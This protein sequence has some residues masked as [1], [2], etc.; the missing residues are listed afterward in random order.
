M[1]EIANIS[2]M[3][4][5][6]EIEFENNRETMIK[7]DHV[8]MEFNMASEQLNSLKE[9]A[10]KLAKR[11]LYFKGFKALDNVSFEVKKGDV[12]GI[13]GTNGSGKSTLLKIIAGVLEPSEGKCTVKGRIA[14]LIELGAGFDLEL[15]ARE[16]IYL[17]G[18][19]LGYPKNFIN[20]HF[21]GIVEF[22]EIE[23][24]LDM[25]MKN[26]SSG[27]VARIAFAIATVIVPEV[28]IVDEVLSVGDFMFQKK[29]ED[30]IKEL[31]EIHGVTVLI[32][33]HSHDQIERLCNKVIWIDKGCTLVVGKTSEISKRYRILGGRAGSDESKQRVLR[34]FE[35]E[36]EITNETYKIIAGSDFFE[37]AVLAASNV[38]SKS[39]LGAVCITSGTSHINTVLANG[40]SGAYDAPILPTKTEGLPI[41]VKNFLESRKPKKIFFFDCGSQTRRALRELQEFNWKPE[42]VNFSNEGSVFDLSKDIFAYGKKEKVWGKQAVVVD[43][44]DNV[45]SLAAASYVYKEKCPV[46]SSSSTHPMVTSELLEIL[47]TAKISEVIIIGKNAN[48]DIEEACRK[49]NINCI[50]FASEQVYESCI[51]LCDWIFAQ[52]DI[53]KKEL[54]ISSQSLSQWPDI[55]SCGMYC[56]HKKSALL[57]GDPT[58]LDSI[59][60]CLNFIEE[61]R[62]SISKLTFFGGDTN[63][64][65]V[66]KETLFK[67]LLS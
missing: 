41:S 18:A 3:T 33:S 52:S 31:I 5:E 25:P 57:L 66:E 55:L 47:S 42:I 62:S 36:Y 9:Y 11:Q 20:E 16:N 4:P 58:N 61:K 49:R 24:F 60:A 30:R 51:K 46:F 26:F 13:I 32:V 63:L 28:L 65:E 17:N 14:P 64:S 39:K 22:A 1:P 21:D 56:S 48:T 59:A 15:T 6:E 40:L 45:E 19:L 53:S 54:C 27:M 44:E 38:Y 67:E 23:Q 50:R 43:F 7:V 2:S 8:S 34:S 35:K 29:C 37:T 12:F 10:I